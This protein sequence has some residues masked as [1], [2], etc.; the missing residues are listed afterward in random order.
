MFDHSAAFAGDALYVSGGITDDPNDPI[1]TSGL[2]RLRLDKNGAANGSWEAVAPMQHRRQQ[3]V[4]VAYEGRLLVFGGTSVS[5]ADQAFG[6]PEPC[7][8]NEVFDPTAGAWSA[9]P[10]TPAH[11]RRIFNPH[12][13]VDDCLYL[14]AGEAEA[15][16]LRCFHLGLGKW[17]DVEGEDCLGEIC[18]HLAYLEVGLPM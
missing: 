17:L 10:E 18:T 7:L 13:V 15:K 2:F 1:P 8:N 12:V 14:C 11:F 5:S 9:L 6:Q 4:M 16:Y 3:H